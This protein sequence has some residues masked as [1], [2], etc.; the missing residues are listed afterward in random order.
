MN[1]L[2]AKGQKENMSNFQN[3]ILLYL[4]LRCAKILV[5]LNFTLSKSVS[6]LVGF[7]KNIEFYNAQTCVQVL[8]AN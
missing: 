8:V 1:T 4:L 3:S 7:S 2:W 5:F 6:L